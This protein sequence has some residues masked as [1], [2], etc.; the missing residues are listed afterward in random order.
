[1]FEQ[2]LG[3][4]IIIAFIFFMVWFFMKELGILKFL[5]KRLK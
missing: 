4:I 5:Q 1:M 3:S 2:I